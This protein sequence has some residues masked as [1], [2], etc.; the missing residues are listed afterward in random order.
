MTTAV[1]DDRAKAVAERMEKPLIVA[2]LLTIPTTVLQF[3][4]VVEPWRTLGDV[5]DWAI[6]LVFLVALVVMLAVVP[7]RGRYLFDHPLEVGIVALTPPFFLAA[8]QSIRLLRLLRLLRLVRLRG[9]S[10]A[11]FSMEGVRFAA[12]VALLTAVGGGAA[13]AAVEH[14]SYGNGVFWAISTMA[15][16][17]SLVP[18]TVAGKVIAV[19]V[20][21]VGIGAAT[22]VI[23]AVAQRFFAQTVEEVELAEDDLLMQVRDISQRLQ[24]LERALSGRQSP[25]ASDR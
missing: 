8:M 17:G 18:H 3:V 13:F 2:A 7:N 23:G 15:T 14:V 12:A 9:S 4:H 25:Q 24:S 5:L 22:L 19:P 20:M 6:W 21:L 11:V 10:S 16:V 1:M